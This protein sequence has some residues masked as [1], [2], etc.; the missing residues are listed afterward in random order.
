MQTL[1][2]FDTRSLELLRQIAGMQRAME[3]RL[4]R[5]ET[6]Q[7]RQLEADGHEDLVPV[8]EHEPN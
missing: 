2:D 4:I 1:P 5:I 8:R 7:C 3:R 6:R